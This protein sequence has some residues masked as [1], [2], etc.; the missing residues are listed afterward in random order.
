MEFKA[1]QKCASSKKAEQ[2]NS[3]PLLDM[4]TAQWRVSVIAMRTADLL[5]CAR[6][7]RQAWPFKRSNDQPSVQHADAI[8]ESDIPGCTRRSHKM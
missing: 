6:D 8:D 2:I 1:P 3:N 5:K 4:R 7:M